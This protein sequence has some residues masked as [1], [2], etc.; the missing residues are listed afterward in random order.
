MLSYIDNL[1]D[2]FDDTM[3][4][5]DPISM[6]E[7]EA[8]EVNINDILSIGDILGHGK[9]GVV[10]KAVILNTNE[11]V[12]VKIIRKIDLNEK[13]VGI[14]K[15]VLFSSPHAA[16]MSNH[17]RAAHPPTHHLTEGFLPGC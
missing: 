11:V 8:S 4:D 12:A 15:V 17:V 10:R 5:V 14:L 13:D 9:Y 16:R 2:G 1:V 7:L 3:I 6:T